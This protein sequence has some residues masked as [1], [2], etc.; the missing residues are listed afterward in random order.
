MVKGKFVEE[1]IAKIL[2]YLSLAIVFYFV[3]SVIWTIFK[4]GCPV[5]TWKMITELPSG[6]FYIGGEGGFLNAIVGSVYIVGASTL[7][8]LLIALP[9]VFYLNVYLKP[10]SKFGYIARLAFDT[11][12]GIPSI[13]YGA[14]AF[15]LMIWLGM[16]ASLAGG[17]LVITLLIIPIFIRSM[18]E[19][20]KSIPKDILEVSYSL[21][22]TRLETIGVVL[23]QIAPAIATATLLGIGRAIGDCA[24]V[25]FTAGFSDHIPKSLDQ[26]AATLPLSIFFQLSAPQQSVQDRA[27]AA[28]VVL[29]VIVLVLSLGGRFIL[30]HFS[31]NKV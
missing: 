6:G 4:R 31:K 3:V 11:L 14:F 17:I 24:G 12:F 2:M 20:A 10:D 28:A 22:S 7:L 30:N 13:V 8:G 23:R 29:T 18:D 9:V 1:K 16:R 19:V 25:M 26:Q 5:L 21:G 27:Y 15:S